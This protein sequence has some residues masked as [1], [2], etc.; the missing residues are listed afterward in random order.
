MSDVEPEQETRMVL[1][2]H[3]DNEIFENYNDSRIH[4]LLRNQY[5]KHIQF[6]NN[7][8]KDYKKVKLS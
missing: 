6:G 5:R 1:H 7:A 4:K 3:Y 2:D 8:P